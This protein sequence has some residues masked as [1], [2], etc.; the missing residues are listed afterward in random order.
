MRL[1]TV[2]FLSPFCWNQR[3]VTFYRKLSQGANGEI[4]CTFLVLVLASV[5]LQQLSDGAEDSNRFFGSWCSSLTTML[6]LSADEDMIA[7]IR[8]RLDVDGVVFVLVVVSMC[9]LLKAFLAKTVIA[10]MNLEM[11]ESIGKKMMYQ[12]FLTRLAEEHPGIDDCL[13]HRSSGHKETFEVLQ[14][15]ESLVL[16]HPERAASYGKLITTKNQTKGIEMARWDDMLMGSEKVLQIALYLMDE[17]IESKISVAMAQSLEDS[18]W[19]TYTDSFSM[20]MSEDTW[21]TWLR[22]IRT[23]QKYGHAVLHRWSAC[24]ALDLVILLPISLIGFF[25]TWDSCWISGSAL[26]HLERFFLFAFTIECMAKIFTLG[27]FQER[28][29]YFH[30]IQ[31]CWDFAVL[32]LFWLSIFR[33]LHVPARTVYC[34]RLVRLLQWLFFCSWNLRWTMKC[35]VSSLEHLLYI[36]MALSCVVAILCPVSFNI[37]PTLSLCKALSRCKSFPIQLTR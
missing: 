2:V 35:I 3:I 8:E 21:N 12:L 17:R 37:C 28:N 15:A 16:K 10:T 19:S 23:L 22:R 7:I 9:F 18:K 20:V 1:F 25:C 13:R 14:A 33:F 6:R 26:W 30:S 5:I 11:E 27:G 29:S 24:L 31:N 34:T 36:L 4:V 32:T